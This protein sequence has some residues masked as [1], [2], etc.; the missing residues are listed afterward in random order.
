M[1][2]NYKVRKADQ[3]DQDFLFEMLYLSIYVE[4]GAPK[5]DRSIV[6]RPEISKYVENWG[7]DGDFSLIALNEDGIRMG[8]VWLRYFDSSCKGYGFI[9]DEIPEIG[10]AVMEEYRGKGVGSFLLEEVLKRAPAPSISLSV[11]SANPAAELYK[12]FGFYSCED[13][14]DSIIMRY[15]N[16]A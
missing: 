2:E 4:Q 5:P 14:G 7:R 10:I 16:N 8:A 3:G 11:Q 13:D 6:E 1:K 12:R 9:S 15:D